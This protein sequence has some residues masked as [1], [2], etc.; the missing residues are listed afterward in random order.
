MSPSRAGNGFLELYRLN[1]AECV[2]IAQGVKDPLQ[3]AALVK[4]AKSWLDLAQ[5]AQWLD[6]QGSVAKVTPQQG[7]Q[8]AP[9]RAL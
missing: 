1:A 8:Q 7:T 9:R 6:K 5:Y 2:E 4:I 3:K